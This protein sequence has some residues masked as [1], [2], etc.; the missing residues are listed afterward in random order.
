MIRQRFGPS[1]AG[2]TSAS[3]ASLGEIV[4]DDAVAEDV[5]QEAHVKAFQHLG[6]FAQ[7]PRFPPGYIGLS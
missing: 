4:R 3:F 6:A 1:C 7:I 2:I 5:V